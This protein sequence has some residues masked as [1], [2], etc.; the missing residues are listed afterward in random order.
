[1]KN[2]AEREKAGRHVRYALAVSDSHGVE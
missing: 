1:M 2:D